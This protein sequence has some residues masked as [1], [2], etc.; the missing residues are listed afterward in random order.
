M[1]V[2]PDMHVGDYG[3]AFIMT[4]LDRATNKALPLSGVT[5]MII[6]FRAP[7]DVET[8]VRNAVMAT[9]PLGADGKL[10]YIFQ[11]G[12]IEIA[13]T[14]EAQALVRAPEGQWHTDITTIEVGE[15]I[16]TPSS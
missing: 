13:G 16:P 2:K 10:K 11:E 6:L 4:V 7:E 8:F 3:T 14:W 1:T 15:N 9:P 5:T 12:D